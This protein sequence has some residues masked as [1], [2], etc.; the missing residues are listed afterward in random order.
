MSAWIYTKG[1]GIAYYTLGK[2]LDAGVDIAFSTRTGGCSGDAFVA[3][4]LGLHVQDDPQRVIL[5]RE[6]FL[7][8][9]QLELGQAVCCL[10]VHGNN[11]MRVD[12]E[13]QGRGA[14]IYDTSLPDCDGLVTSLPGTA[15]LTFYADCVPVFLFDPHRRVI[16][17]LHSGWKGTMHRIA[18]KAIV[19]MQNEFGSRV[20]DLW[21]AIGPGIG[22]CCFE[23]ASSLA[24]EVEKSFAG[25]KN[26]LQNRSDRFYW[27]LAATIL[28]MLQQTGIEPKNI[29]TCSLCT[30]CHP[31]LFYSYRRDRGITGRMGA[32]LNLRY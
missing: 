20:G 31:E 9:F 15:L 1:N 5:N 28:Q 4:N 8:N 18:E 16:A 12:K 22:G 23:I 2:W 27:D 10:Q 17:L 14:Y 6:K 29:D 11:I 30:A 21:A 7:A 3:A 26:I 32:L 24:G 13:Q 25:Y 19:I